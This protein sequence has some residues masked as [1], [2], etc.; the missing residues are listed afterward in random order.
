LSR[1]SVVYYSNGEVSEPLQRFCLEILA[2]SVAAC[3]GDLVCVTW[4]PLY[5]GAPVTKNLVWPRHELAHQNMYEQILAGISEARG[6]T[7]ALAEHDVLYPKSYCADMAEA[8]ATGLCYNNSIWCLNEHGFFRAAGCH[9]LSNCCGPRDVVAAGIEGKLAEIRHRGRVD[10][11]EP[12][13]DSEVSL[14]HPTVDV[15]HGRNFTG[16][17]EAA[18]YQSRIEYWGEASAYTRLFAA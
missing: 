13:G 11:A 6:E 14:I 18:E 7:I 2:E 1:S 3:G 16:R 4:E 8:G 10:W 9:F 15:R 12:P 5:D 17:R